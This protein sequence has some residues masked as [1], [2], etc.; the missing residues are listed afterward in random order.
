MI[1][2]QRYRREYD[3]ASGGIVIGRKFSARSIK[4]S[5][6]SLRDSLSRTLDHYH[7]HEPFS[8]RQCINTIAVV[9]VVDHHKKWSNASVHRPRSA[10]KKIWMLKTP[11]KKNMLT[12]CIFPLEKKMSPRDRSR[13]DDYCLEGLSWLLFVPGLT[14]IFFAM[15]VYQV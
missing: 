10:C 6:V 5:L 15:G 12:R 2:T 3:Q 11:W 8:L 7:L 9:V 1:G 13:Y 4:C 14:I